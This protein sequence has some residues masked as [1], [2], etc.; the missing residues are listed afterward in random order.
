MWVCK[1]SVMTALHCQV[2]TPCV[3]NSFQADS[4]SGSGLKRDSSYQIWQRAPL[5]WRRCPGNWW[6]RTG[7]SRCL[8]CPG[9]G[10]EGVT[11]RAWAG[12]TP[13]SA[14]APRGRR[15]S[16]SAPSASGCRTRGRKARPCGPETWWCCSWGL[17]DGWRG[18]LE[19]VRGEVVSFLKK[20]IKAE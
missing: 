4:G 12:T 16:A 2:C 19:E 13:V 20:E 10:C 8:W 6:P 3:S 1:T 17:R 15:S 18:N 5:W 14:P 7:S 11:R 9:C